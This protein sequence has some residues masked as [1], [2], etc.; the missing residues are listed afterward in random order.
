LT[1]PPPKSFLTLPKKAIIN[2]P[3]ITQPQ[4]LLASGE[5][6]KIPDTRIN[7]DLNDS[8]RSNNSSIA[9]ELNNLTNISLG[10]NN[11]EPQKQNQQS[12][13]N[14]NANNF[15]TSSL[16]ASNN[17]TQL[18]GTTSQQQSQ[19]DFQELS[20]YQSATTRFADHSINKSNS[21]STS[22]INQ[23]LN[24]SLSFSQDNRQNNQSSEQNLSTDKLTPVANTLK[25]NGL[26]VNNTNTHNYFQK[27]T[28]QNQPIHH[29]SH[30][31]DLNFPP[32]HDVTSIIQK[33][34]NQMPE[35]Q[36]SSFPQQ[37][38]P[39]TVFPQQPIP[40]TV[41]PQQPIPNTV[42]PQQPIPNTVFPQQP[43]S[44][45]NT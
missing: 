28:Q 4:Q 16:P 23:S 32:T 34:I 11:L 15:L 19:N 26:N 38:I 3:H 24:N 18:F 8:F 20:Y 30:S 22:S 12:F 25:N 40:N 14:S 2:P 7:P 45:T 27:E 42:F 41:F 6:T 43:I 10:S 9:S 5:T 37:P 29:N 36:Q 44:T 17:V 31:R 39:N 33:T 35:Q 21:T 13:N 1:A